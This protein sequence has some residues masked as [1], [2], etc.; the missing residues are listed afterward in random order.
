MLAD[1]VECSCKKIMEKREFPPDFSP[2]SSLPSKTGSY[3]FAENLLHKFTNNDNFISEIPTP[4]TPFQKI[5]QKRE[6]WQ[7]VGLLKPVVTS[8]TKVVIMT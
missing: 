4:C 2:E 1:C 8:Y 6:L 7:R 5:F 3:C